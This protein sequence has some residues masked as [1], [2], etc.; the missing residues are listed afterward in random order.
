[1]PS[2]RLQR[3]LSR[4][5]TT[6]PLGWIPTW[7]GLRAQQ[8]RVWGSGRK[9]KE[10]IWGENFQWPQTEVDWREEMQCPVF[11]ASWRTGLWVE[12]NRRASPNLCCWKSG[13]EPQITGIL[14]HPLDSS[15]LCLLDKPQWEIEAEQ[16][17]QEGV[18][19]QFGVGS[20]GTQSTDIVRG[21]SGCQALLWRQLTPVMGPC[22]YT[23]R[24]TNQGTKWRQPERWMA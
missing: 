8:L 3:T 5:T 17:H 20:H 9:G 24:D 23:V 18:L 19:S 21:P 6:V 1:M 10:R 2:Y 7:E 4:L 12:G 13:S 14:R 16:R 15:S 22:E 11:C